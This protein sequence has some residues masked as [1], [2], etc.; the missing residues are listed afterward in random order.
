MAHTA[1]D[2]LWMK[3]I[4]QEIGFVSNNPMKMYCDNQAAMYI[5]SNP[6]FHKWTKHIEVDCH[7]I[8]DMVMRKQIVTSFVRSNNQLGDIFTRSLN[9]WPFYDICNK[10]G[11]I[12]I[13]ALA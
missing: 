8:R 10:L 2:M 12:N 11:M 5:A 1:G 4:L 7:F 3:T 13:Y 6:V 9:K